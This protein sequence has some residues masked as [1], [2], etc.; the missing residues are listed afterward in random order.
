MVFPKLSR[1]VTQSGLPNLGGTYS[2][3]ERQ[4]QWVKWSKL[5]VWTNGFQDFD[6]GVGVQNFRH[7][8]V[9]FSQQSA[10][11]PATW[12]RKR[13]RHGFSKPSWPYVKPT[14]SASEH[15]VCGIAPP[16]NLDWFTWF[17]GK[18]LYFTHLNEGHLGVISLANHDSRDRSQW[19]RYN[20]PS[21]MIF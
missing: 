17:L 9:S 18:S 21:L 19:G 20:W 4:F 15:V 2:T 12:S 3:S 13:T 7:F 6:K 16:W 8:Q 10:H 1:P 14:W 5:N 11:R